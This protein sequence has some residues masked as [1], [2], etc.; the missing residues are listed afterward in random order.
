MKVFYSLPGDL[1]LCPQGKLWGAVRCI[2]E[3]PPAIACN[4]KANIDLIGQIEQPQ[5]QMN[6]SISKS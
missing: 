4:G 3:H 6:Q 1:V 5:L 2:L